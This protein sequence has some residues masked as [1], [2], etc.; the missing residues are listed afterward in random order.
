MRK[1]MLLFLAILAL[2]LLAATEAAKV[3]IR[4]HPE[5]K[6]TWLTEGHLSVK[7]WLKLPTGEVNSAEEQD[8]LW[9]DLVDERDLAGTLALVRQ[10][11]KWN[12]TGDSVNLAPPGHWHLTIS[13]LYEQKMVAEGGPPG[14]VDQPALFPLRNVAVGESWPVE[15]TT[16]GTVAIDSKKLPIQTRLLGTGK[17]VSLDEK[18]AVLE[19]SLQLTSQG[20]GPGAATSSQSKVEW[21]MH[22]DRA[23]GVPI[24]QKTVSS[25]EQTVT[26]GGSIIIPSRSDTVLELKTRLAP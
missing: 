1:S 5:P 20:Q 24:W 2:P 21:T 6:T 15:Q 13:K 9:E 7:S 12:R 4:Y 18:L 25:T 17:L 14:M 3:Q 22:V 11:R 19:F 23:T 26:L 8:L 16:T 10:V